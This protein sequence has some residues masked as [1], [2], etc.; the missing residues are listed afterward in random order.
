MSILGPEATKLE[1][2]FARMKR[3]GLLDIK[4]SF[5]DLGEAT[6]EDVCKC[7]NE[8]LDAIENGETEDITPSLF[9]K[10]YFADRTLAGDRT[11]PVTGKIFNIND[12]QR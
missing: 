11:D 10:G 12:K 9:I 1:E 8:A 4:I 6:L 5:G 2:R 3:A 7:V